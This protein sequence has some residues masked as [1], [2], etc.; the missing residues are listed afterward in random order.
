MVAQTRPYLINVKYQCDEE[1]LQ[2]E[3]WYFSPIAED[4]AVEDLNEISAGVITR[5]SN[6]MEELMPD[7]MIVH[8]VT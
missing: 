6:E 5:W 4:L 2:S 1:I 8:S 3:I 7:G